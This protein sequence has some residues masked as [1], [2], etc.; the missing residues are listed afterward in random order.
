MW[1]IRT[2]II[3]QK[4]LSKHFQ[5][6]LPTDRENIGS[7]Y[8]RVGGTEKQSKHD[9]GNDK[10]SHGKDPYCSSTTNT[11]AIRRSRGVCSLQR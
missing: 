2:M 5:S 3:F 6:A 9:A 8:A 11:T 4:P 7:N 1:I 10:C